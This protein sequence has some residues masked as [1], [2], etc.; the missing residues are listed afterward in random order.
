MYPMLLK[1]DKL[2]T[3]FPFIETIAYHMKTYPGTNV[4]PM[5]SVLKDMCRYKKARMAKGNYRFTIKVNQ[6]LVDILTDAA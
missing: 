2:V 4:D 3:K 5:I 1:V 6:E